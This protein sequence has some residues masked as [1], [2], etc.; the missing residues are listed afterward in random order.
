MLGSD[1]RPDQRAAGDL[2]EPAVPSMPSRSRVAL[3]ERPGQV[4]V[5]QPDPGQLWKPYRLPATVD[6][7]AT[8]RGAEIV[9]RKARRRTMPRR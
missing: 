2:C 3:G 1:D 4:D 5:H 9:E 8:Q 6:I 7:S